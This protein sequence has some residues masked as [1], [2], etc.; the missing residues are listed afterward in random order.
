M[1]FKHSS[2]DYY[3]LYIE[4][5]KLQIQRITTFQNLVT[6][7]TVLL[8]THSLK[9]A[10]GS[11]FVKQI[12]TSIEEDE[13]INGMLL[14]DKEEHQIG[15]LIHTFLMEHTSDTNNSIQDFELNVL[16][17][18][19]RYIIQL[20]DNQQLTSFEDFTRECLFEN[21]IIN[22]NNSSV[23]VVIPENLFYIDTLP[24]F[25]EEKL[26]KKI[27]KGFEI[28]SLLKL[29]KETKFP[30]YKNR[31]E[32]ER[33]F[34]KEEIVFNERNIT[35]KVFN[36]DS[37]L[38]EKE[39]F[40]IRELE[41]TLEIV[42]E[43]NFE[44]SIYD[45][46]ESVWSEEDFN[47][48]N[49]TPENPPTPITEVLNYVYSENMYN[50]TNMKED[51][52][53]KTSTWN[54]TQ[55]LLT[56]EDKLFKDQTE[57]LEIEYLIDKTEMNNNLQELFS[58]ADTSNILLQLTKND[59]TKLV[60]KIREWCLECKEKE[61]DQERANL[62]NLDSI[63]NND[64][65]KLL[66]CPLLEISLPKVEK[67]DS[68]IPVE[69]ILKEKSLNNIELSLQSFWYSDFLYKSRKEFELID[70]ISNYNEK[71]M[72]SKGDLP[73]KESKEEN[74]L[75]VSND[76][77]RLFLSDDTIKRNKTIERIIL[78]LEKCDEMEK[79]TL[80]SDRQ[81]LRDLTN[82]LDH[83]IETVN[84]YKD[85]GKGAIHKYFS[86][87]DSLPSIE[88][89]KENTL[90]AN[91]YNEEPNDD[92]ILSQKNFTSYNN[93]NN[94]EENDLSF[95]SIKTQEF[96]NSFT[97]D[98][99]NDFALL[100]NIILEDNLEMFMNQK[101]GI[102]KEISKEKSVK[103]PKETIEIPQDAKVSKFQID[104]IKKIGN[105]NNLI[106]F[107]S[108]ISYN[109]TSLLIF[110]KLKKCSTNS[111]MLWID[112]DESRLEQAYQW[113]CAYLFTTTRQIILINK[114]NFTV[115]LSNISDNC[116][117]VFISSKII[118]SF[119]QR[120]ENFISRCALI[121]FQDTVLSSQIDTSQL[122]PN[123]LRICKITETTWGVS[124]KNVQCIVLSSIPSLEL[125]QL[126]KFMESM[127]IQQ[128]IYKTQID[129]EVKTIS[130][131][132]KIKIAIYG[133]LSH[134]LNY[135]TKVGNFIFDGISNYLKGY[136][137]QGMNFNDIT[138]DVY[139]Q[140]VQE[141][142]SNLKVI[143]ASKQDQRKILETRNIFKK[144]VCIHT[145]KYLYEA[146]LEAG[147]NIGYAY[148]QKI[149]KNDTYRTVLEGSVSDVNEQLKK[150]L[151]D[152]KQEEHP[153]FKIILDT[154]IDWIGEFNNNN[155]TMKSLL[156]TKHRGVQSI[157]K[158]Y[159][160]E[161]CNQ[162]NVGCYTIEMPNATNSSFTS[163]MSFPTNGLPYCLSVQNDNC[164]SL[165][166]TLTKQNESQIYITTY[167][168]LSIIM[169]ENNLEMKSTHQKIEKYLNGVIQVETG[170]IPTLLYS[171]ITKQLI[172]CHSYESFIENNNDLL[173]YD[174]DN[175]SQQ[176]CQQLQLKFKKNII[177]LEN[178]KLFTQKC[179]RNELSLF[180]PE[181]IECIKKNFTKKFSRNNS[182]LF[183]IIVTDSCIQNHELIRILEQRFNIA[184]EERSS[185][186]FS[187]SDIVVNDTHCIIL[188][189]F[190]YEMFN[191]QNK[192]ELIKKYTTSLF[193]KLVLLGMQF[194]YCWLIFENY[195]VD[196]EK[197]NINIIDILSISAASLLSFSKSLNLEL[198]IKHSYHLD[199]TAELIY[200]ICQQ[201]FR[202][203]KTLH[204]E[205]LW[206]KEKES[207]SEQF[208]SQ[209]PCHNLYTSQALL[210][211][212]TL[213]ELTR[214]T[215]LSS[216][217]EQFESC[218]SEDSL[219][220][221]HNLLH[222]LVDENHLLL[223]DNHEALDSS[224]N[225]DLIED[226]EQ[227]SSNHTYQ[228]Q[229]YEPDNWHQ[230]A[231]Q[232][233]LPFFSSNFLK[234][235]ACKF[236]HQDYTNNN[237]TFYPQQELPN[238]NT[239]SSF[240]NN[241]NLIYNKENARTPS[242]TPTSFSQKEIV[243]KSPNEYSF[244][245]PHRLPTNRIYPSKSNTIFNNDQ[246]QLSINSVDHG[247]QFRNNI[248]EENNIFKTHN[249]INTKHQL[250]R[251]PVQRISLSSNIPK[252]KSKPIDFSQFT[253]KN[254][255]HSSQSQ[256]KLPQTTNNSYQSKYTRKKK[257]KY[258]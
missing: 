196:N 118:D 90:N 100:H 58:I 88:E 173:A 5:L 182:L 222:E 141:Y 40:D 224:N 16:G 99:N 211:K 69:E 138:S 256:P 207:S 36:V 63:L 230:H 96:E 206:I 56:E 43:S 3:S 78:L 29:K 199:Q 228:Q 151:L 106:T 2:I 117:I 18:T 227:L 28:E 225:E 129:P 98:N 87:V 158:K 27:A 19:S 83:Y 137:L 142:S 187:P 12:K 216:F 110:N 185:S 44:K 204:K 26:Y 30:E 192:D 95:T 190:P 62:F 60:P 191:K 23:E 120:F 177:S 144:L 210:Q 175:L 20:K 67:L 82:Q 109:I 107:P 139:K 149:E 48:P 171:Y 181:T 150:I 47:L 131:N 238:N 218:M 41:E 154:L 194:K 39:Y 21:K 174:I 132:Q 133:R 124:K 59:T 76:D 160:I 127:F 134:F 145:L 179:R 61:I 164:C 72:T 215:D 193:E 89:F 214:I 15:E 119:M 159:L 163:E 136:Y 213:K 111:T 176:F 4:R 108:T 252:L 226:S 234:I 162:F 13:T 97:S 57:L 116:R 147:P 140:I 249:I 10:L 240:P 233:P 246:K 155:T 71:E 92:N 31:L 75:K 81:F 121:I 219:T 170:N 236:H 22:C 66:P 45:F 153:K 203:A 125:I 128:L 167:S 33:K 101:Q 115:Q 42:K 85:D 77:F 255:N 130:C 54:H 14:V 195:L 52:E 243:H 11:C 239:L 135:V 70:E 64:E 112:N 258:N 248:I 157:L 50:E 34:L 209:F 165:E 242:Y 223:K 220:I 244:T 37:Y 161:F 229:Q 55:L 245:L 183:K 189:H 253:Y 105:E 1:S 250:E 9:H 104:L 232:S 146:V 46:S 51:I 68:V 102:D 257:P 53:I 254:G 208:L 166:E 202:Q 143:L 221:F 168:N 235:L 7:N 8:N 32:S 178:L 113:H 169:N 198:N 103:K 74:K 247:Q 241:R 6:P 93:Y 94:Q 237:N 201:V 114:Q 73:W 84:Y 24:L 212:C 86:L 184:T 180:N 148:L 38:F 200:S 80:K 49:N 205:I 152:E 197:Q 126:N 156:I 251:T 122:S 123:Q 231:P 186:I 217:L 17:I 79:E 65:V 172:R 25:T 35:D 188:T 91:T